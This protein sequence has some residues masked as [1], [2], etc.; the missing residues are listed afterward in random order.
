MCGRKVGWK[1]CFLNSL[2]CGPYL[3]QYLVTKSLLGKLKQE[4]VIWVHNFQPFTEEDL[5]EGLRVAWFD[6][7]SITWLIKKEWMSQ[8]RELWR[9]AALLPSLIHNACSRFPWP[10]PD[11]SQREEQKQLG[12]VKYRSYT[13][14]PWPTAHWLGCAY[15]AAREAGK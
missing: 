14:P 8:S 2:E 4:S 10:R 1:R 3:V 15:T 7:N 9:W 6:K 13:Q 12:K 5:Q 11:F